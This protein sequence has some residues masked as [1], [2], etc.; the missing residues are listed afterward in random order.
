MMKTLDRYLLREILVPFF[1]VLFILTFVL[2][3]GR[4]L[5]I[6]DLMVNK[7]IGFLPMSKFLIYL[8]PSFLIRTIPISL[9]AAVLIGLG[10]LSGDSELIV[11]KASG[12][13]LSRIAR[14]IFALAVAASLF[15]ASMALFISP[16][17][18]HAMRS[19]LFDMARQKAG[20]GIKEKVFNNQFRDMVLYAERIDPRGNFMENVFIADNR[21]LKEPTVITARKAFLVSDPERM[22]LSFRLLQGST[23]QADARR[24]TYKKMD[25]DSYDLNLDLSGDREAEVL[26]RR[27]S[28][29]MGLPDLLGEIRGSR[30]DTP[31]GRELLI[32]LNKK[33]TL[34]L[35]CILFALVGIPLSMS[36]HRSGR[37][38]GFSLAIAIIMIYYILQLSVESLGERGFLPPVPGAW[39]P[40][41]LFAVAGGMLFYRAS[42][43]RSLFPEGA[44]RRRM[45]LPA[46]LSRFFR[47]GD[48]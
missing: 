5:Q 42:R 40:D 4:I 43:E 17:S 1:M 3:I 7:G 13:S 15:T 34:P 29:E 31:E 10:R 46:I 27:K 48:R 47:K 38:W 19:L 21:L 37:A 16:A 11:M 30:P 25:F 44:S 39:I 12:I 26:S 35:S 14:P 18:N 2:L 41:G 36:R 33:F 9:L 6:M 32:E 8:M 22:S 20:V 24:G 45:P 23:H 28:T